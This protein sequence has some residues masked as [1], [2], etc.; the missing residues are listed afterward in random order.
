M[1]AG[2]P[3]PADA[4]LLNMAER[5]SH[6]PTRSAAPTHGIGDHRPPRSVE[7]RAPSPA[8]TSRRRS[9][10]QRPAH[11]VPERRLGVHSTKEKVSQN[12]RPRTSSA[13]RPDVWPKCRSGTRHRR[14]GPG[15]HWCQSGREVR[16]TL[17]RWALLTHPTV[18]HVWCGPGRQ[19]CRSTKGVWCRVHR[20]VWR[21]S[22]RRSA[23][24]SPARVTTTPRAAIGTAR[25]RDRRFG[26][27]LP[28]FACRYARSPQR[29]SYL[30][31]AGVQEQRLGSRT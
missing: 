7:R 28:A 3:G 5:R 13:P 15:Q 11:S 26:A 25:C 2:H 24:K 10:C 9:R 31:G 4:P 30:F 27:R 19:A 18:A 21:A 17:R 23:R 1:R 6:P 8:R 12:T 16:A 29:G 20:R 14:I 22:C